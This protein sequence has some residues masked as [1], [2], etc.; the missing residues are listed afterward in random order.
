[1][2][3]LVQLRKPK[4]TKLCQAIANNDDNA[5]ILSGHL[6]RVGSGIPLQRVCKSVE[7]EC[8]ALCSSSAEYLFFLY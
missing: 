4:W 8:T 7:E 1:M 3:L 6:E 5:Y 2:G